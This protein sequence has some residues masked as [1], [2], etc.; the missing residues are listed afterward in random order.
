MNVTL[1]LKTGWESHVNS[2]VSGWGFNTSSNTNS[3]WGINVT[4]NESSDCTKLSPT[5]YPPI[6]HPIKYVQTRYNNNDISIHMRQ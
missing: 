2:T 4:S 1:N 5:F 3:D 6:Y